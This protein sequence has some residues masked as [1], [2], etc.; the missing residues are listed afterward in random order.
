[1]TS[2]GRLTMTGDPLLALFDVDGTQI[3]QGCTPGHFAVVRA[4]ALELYG[5]GADPAAAPPFRTAGMTELQIARQVLTDAGVTPGADLAG[6]AARFCAEISCRFTCPDLSGHVIPGVPGV[7]AELASDPDVVLG[8]VTGCAQ[9]IAQAKLAAAGLDRFF[10][11]PGIGGF[12]DD[13]E[14]RQLLVPI[15]RRRAGGPWPRHRTLV[16]GDTPADI[17]CARADQVRC[18]GFAAGDYSTA[19]LA[20]ADRVACDAGQLLAAIRAEIGP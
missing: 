3:T 18:I 20:A 4:T 17:A 6:E 8:L 13:A 10:W 2:G 5:N 7:L 12:G 11:P 16:I 19:D 9:A 1:V 15:A 14:D